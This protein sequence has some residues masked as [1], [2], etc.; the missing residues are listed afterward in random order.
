MAMAGAD[1]QKPAWEMRFGEL[2]GQINA[3]KLHIVMNVVSCGKGKGQKQ[4]NGCE[5][6]L[7]WFIGLYM[8]YS[9][10]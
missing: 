4:I 9:I 3:L 6:S 7:C 10:S 5:Q 1:S 2:G 8:S